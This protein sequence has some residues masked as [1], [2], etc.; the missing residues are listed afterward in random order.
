LTQATGPSPTGSTRYWRRCRPE[1]PRMQ[2]RD[3]RVI[4]LRDRPS[5]ERR[6]GRPMSS[7]GTH[8]LATRS[9]VAVSSWHRCTRTSATTAPTRDAG[10]HNILGELP[11]DCP[12]IAAGLRLPRRARERRSAR[13]SVPARMRR[14]PST[15]RSEPVA[16]HPL[17]RWPTR[18]NAI[19]RPRGAAR[20]AGSSS[21]R[22]VRP[23]SRLPAADLATRE[24]GTASCSRRARPA[25]A[26]AGSA[27]SSG[28][29]PERRN[30]PRHH[31]RP[32]E[33]SESPR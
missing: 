14:R 28:A 13:G 17:R 19:S 11:K 29:V 9:E 30:R 27:T 8:P 18:W 16:P 32:A 25:H 20:P 22:R 6:G 10:V 12:P 1:S 7:R 5:P 2:G 15:T 3:T 24:I 21:S 23:S 33:Q 26:G 31:A 4:E